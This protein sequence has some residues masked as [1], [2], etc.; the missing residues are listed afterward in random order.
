MA[1]GSNPLTG[2]M[3]AA[4][5][6]Q[7]IRVVSRSRGPAPLQHPQRCPGI[8]PKDDRIRR[9]RFLGGLRSASLAA[10][11]S[12]GDST[13]LCASGPAHAPASTK[14]HWVWLWGSFSVRRSTTLRFRLARAN[15]CQSNY[16]Q[17]TKHAR[18]QHL[19]TAIHIFFCS[20][21]PRASFRNG[22]RPV[23]HLHSPADSSDRFVLPLVGGSNSSPS[24]RCRPIARKTACL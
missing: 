1:G 12:S 23:P 13:R 14:F 16:P 22:G 11:G 3:L 7:S 18:P 17:D 5:L 8:S 9:I 2:D 4:S 24:P 19:V 20:A 15:G 10:T 6:R 21:G